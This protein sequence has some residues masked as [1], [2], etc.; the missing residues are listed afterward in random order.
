MLEQLNVVGHSVVRT[1]GAQ[2]VTGQA[3]FAGDLQLPGMLHCRLVVSQYAHALIRSINIDEAKKV[4]GVVKVVLAADLPIKKEASESRRRNFLAE[5]EIVFYGQPIVAV[6]G[7]T[8]AAAMDGVMAV[9]VDYEP[10]PA[11]TT[12]EMAVKEG[13]PSVRLKATEGHGAD[14]EAQMHATGSVAGADEGKVQLPSN[15]NNR[16][17]I[18][19]G[20]VEAG[21]NEADVVVENTYRLPMVHQSYLEPQVCVAAPDLVG[22]VTVYTSTQAAFYG[23]QEVA[24]ALGIPQNKVK[25]VTMEVGGGF[26]GKFVLLE[27]FTA[28]LAKFAKRPVKMAYNRSEDLVAGNPAPDAVIEVKIGAKKDGTL[29]TIQAKAWVDSGVYAGAPL[30][31]F[32]VVM[33]GYY[34]IPNFEVEA[35]EVLTNRPNVGAYRA[36]GAP[37]AT[38]A[39]EASVDA[40]AKALNMDALELRLKNVVVEGDT[41]ATGRPL[42]RIGAKECL[43]RLYEHPLWKNR[44]NKGANEGIGVALGGWPGGLEP[45]SSTC[46]L[47]HDGNFTVTTGVADLTGVSTSLQLIAAEVLGAKADTVTVNRVD[48]DNAPYVG[49]SGGSKTLYTLGAAV[50]KAAEDAKEQILNIAATMLEAAPQD[51]ELQDGKV[52]VKGLSSRS[53][54]LREIAAKSMNFGG[55]FEPVYGRGSSAI[56][57]NAPGFAAHL[58]HVKVD[59]ET[60]EVE[61]LG[62]VAVQDVGRA[63]NP[64]EVQGQIHGGV[65][66]GL[67]WALY[68]QMVYDEN[69]TLI[70]GTLMDYALQVAS[71]VPNI[72]VQLVEVPA[73]DGPFGA[74]GVG[75]PPIVPGG[76]AVANAIFDATGVRVKELPAVPER[77]L[78]AIEQGINDKLT[79]L[80]SSN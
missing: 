47:D 17:H 73:P 30:F 18:K 65:T 9:E 44:A 42:P 6:L 62:Y 16:M 29:T 8:E 45:A 20:D 26:G 32:P 58:A 39:M 7:E 60:G 21:F 55:R 48:T 70:S 80:N 25:V 57:S 14:S 5:K 69:G 77:V 72:E 24:A 12:V 40:I 15:V 38:F 13:A 66:Q 33:G 71:I 43:E 31:I 50:K 2:K 36:P 74:K 76:A 28:A 68:E 19:R 10:L 63:I 79:K 67:G 35:F 53:V 75:E 61:V 64:A 4:P 41:I 27:P 23:R 46:R 78:S 51:L 49:A 52:T 22:G 34:R 54:S 3:Q 37:Q 1:D 56:T 11:V 59:P